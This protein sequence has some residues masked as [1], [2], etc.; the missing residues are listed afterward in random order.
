M[1]NVTIT[2]PTPV[3]IPPA[4][5]QV[6]YRALG[7]TTWI[8]VPDQSNASF[9]IVGVPEGNWEL[10]VSYV[11][12]DGEVCP[13]VI[14]PF[15]VGAPCECLDISDTSVRRDVPG[16]P[17]Y[18]TIYYAVPVSPAKCGYVVRYAQAGLPPDLTTKAPVYFSTLPTPPI[19]IPVPAL[20]DLDV[21]VFADCCE[22]NVTECFSDT[23]IAI[24]DPASGCD[25]VTL[26]NAIVAIIR[27]ASTGQYHLSITYP[28]PLIGETVPSLCAG[29]YAVVTQIGVMAGHGGLGGVLGRPGEFATIPL[30]PADFF[31]YLSV[32]PRIYRPLHPSPDVD[33]LG[34]RYTVAIHD[35]CGNVVYFPNVIYEGVQI[36]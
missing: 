25:G 30:P 18:L 23:V 11:S 1:A 17:A 22:G 20:V 35:C 15:E 34:I 16:G 29:M 8:A 36:P 4:Y 3:S 27:S 31:M 2:I 21:D 24:Q 13:E 33:F 14:Y 9:V 10:G 7:S 32:A 6:R 28:G 19:K 5:F 26:T 12:S